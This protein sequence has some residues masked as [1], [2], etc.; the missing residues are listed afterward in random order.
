ML[1][2][3]DNIIDSVIGTCKDPQQHELGVLKEPK[4]NVAGEW[5]GVRSE[6][7]TGPLK[8]FWRNKISFSV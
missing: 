8:P 6:R 7:Y 2:F 4:G 1:N 3:V 5:W